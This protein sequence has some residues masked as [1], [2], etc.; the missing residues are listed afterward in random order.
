MNAIRNNLPPTLICLLL[1]LISL[2]TA[3]AYYDPGVQR[4]ISRDPVAEEGGLNLYEFEENAPVSFLDADGG[5][6]VTFP[7]RPPLPPRIKPPLPLGP[8][9]AAITCGAVG[10][11]A[12]DLGSTLYY[13]EKKKRCDKE[14]DD[15]FN[16]CKEELSKPNPSLGITGGYNNIMDCARGLVSEECGGNPLDHG[17]KKKKPPIVRF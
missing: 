4:W 2:R 8:I 15:A 11:A 10:A 14:W 1:L 12:I 9:G 16:M 13:D 6:P 3:S 7:I 5:R 17:K